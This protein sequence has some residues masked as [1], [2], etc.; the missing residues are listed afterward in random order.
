MIRDADTLGQ[1][2]DAI[3]RFVRERLELA[4]ERLAAEGRVP[5]DTLGEMKA[6]GLFGLTIPERYGGLGLTMEEEMLAAISLGRTSPAFRSILGTNNGI[7]SAA[8]VMAGTEEQKRK[9]L[10]RYAASEWI[11]CF[12]LT[13]PDAGSD[14][15]SLKTAAACDGVGVAWRRRV[16]AAME[17]PAAASAAPL[18]GPT[19]GVQRSGRCPLLVPRGGS[20]S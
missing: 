9:Y 11:S 6:L 16:H 8:I 18:S 1:L 19:A 14:A 5:D 4:E 3:D 13:E 12:C 20:M 10:P 15:A 17:V 2:V 7:G